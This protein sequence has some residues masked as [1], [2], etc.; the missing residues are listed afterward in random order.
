MTAPGFSPAES[1]RASAPPRPFSA[2]PP[3]VHRTGSGMLSPPPMTTHSEAPSPLPCMFK[4][5]SEEDFNGAVLKALRD[6]RW[7][8]VRELTQ[9]RRLS[10]QCKE[11]VVQKIMT[12]RG[13]DNSVPTNLPDNIAQIL[14][15]IC[16]ISSRVPRYTDIFQL[17]AFSGEVLLIQKLLEGELPQNRSRIA[18]LAV[19]ANSQGVLQVLLDKEG[20]MDEAAC[21]SSLVEAVR[22]K[23]L[24]M[25]IT[26]L[27]RGLI[28]REALR[29]ARELA[30]ENNL[31]AIDD[32][33]YRF[34]LRFN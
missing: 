27:D 24:S 28:T 23:N 3:R 18:C 14:I 8:D 11:E 22:V 16:P 21:S 4:A 2:P 34:Q 29:A 32:L 33:L 26:L 6:R 5:V 12:R 13:P 7:T 1:G 17:A 25:V 20:F 31:D 19:H 30:T 15:N 9:D 10:E